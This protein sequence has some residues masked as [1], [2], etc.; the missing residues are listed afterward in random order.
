MYAKIVFTHAMHAH[1]LQRYSLALHRHLDVGVPS[2][3]GRQDPE[4]G[5]DY[6]CLGTPQETGKHAGKVTYSSDLVC[7]HFYPEAVIITG[8]TLDKRKGRHG[9]HEVPLTHEQLEAFKRGFRDT[10]AHRVMLPRGYEG[11]KPTWDNGI[12]YYPDMAPNWYGFDEEFKRKFPGV[13]I[14]R[15]HQCFWYELYFT[16]CSFGK[17]FA[18]VQDPIPA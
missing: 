6:I 5:A 12:K 10:P 13:E 18:Y 15:P 4:T 11:G 3:Y 7:G 17:K 8:F 16:D 2:T 1:L 9:S 14:Y